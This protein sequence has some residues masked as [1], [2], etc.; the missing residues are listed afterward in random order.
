MEVI[1]SRY[2]YK[3]KFNKKRPR[4]LKIV[5]WLLLFIIVFSIG[6]YSYTAVTAEVPEVGINISENWVSSPENTSVIWPKNGMAAIGSLEDGVYEI[7]NNL[8]SRAPI[9]SMTK[10]ITALV[11]LDKQPINKDSEQIYT[12]SEKDLLIFNEYLAK[13]GTVLPVNLGQKL[14]QYQML[15][16]MMVISANNVADYLANWTFGSLENYVTYANDY[17]KNNGFTNTVVND[18]S[19]FSPQSFS[20][21]S[22]M[23]KLGQLALK[24]EVIRTV[25]SQ[26]II[27][28]P[29]TGE[30]KNTNQLL[31][32]DGVIGIKTGSTDEAGKCLLFAVKYGPKDSQILIGVIMGQADMSSLYL[33]ARKLKDSALDNF[34]EIEVIPANTIV[35]K[36]NTEWGDVS[37]VSNTE[38]LKYYGWKGKQ[39]KSNIKLNNIE[40]PASKNTLIGKAEVESNNSTTTDLVIQSPISEPS[41]IWRILN[42][43]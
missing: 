16:A 18:A 41:K 34:K 39:Y 20:T 23:I 12:I 30:L 36:V 28:I 17:L 35:G 13:Q 29:G 7:N 38:S 14:T 31:I 37:E 5:S 3:D 8:D 9:A 26:K 21:P 2:K 1:R 22:E 43:W 25:V 19:G 15:Q 40:I 27:N 6:F 32:D 11:I 33:N 10:V 24:N 42:Y 4:K